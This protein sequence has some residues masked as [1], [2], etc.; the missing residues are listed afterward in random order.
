MMAAQIRFQFSYLFNLWNVEPFPNERTLRWANQND[1][2]PIAENFYLA[3]LNRSKL[4]TLTSRTYV[5]GF[6]WNRPSKM[7]CVLASF[8]FPAHRMILL[9][10]LDLA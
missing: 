1:C 3:S 5:S 4:S 9:W 8:A 2:F 10:P 6:Q 7:L